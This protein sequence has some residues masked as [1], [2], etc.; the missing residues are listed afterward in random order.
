[1]G[2]D[3]TNSGKTPYGSKYSHYVVARGLDKDG[4]VIVEDSEDKTVLQDIVL[5]I[6]LII[7]QF[8]LLLVKVDT[9]EQKIML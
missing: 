9:V 1:M 4:N 3:S 5:L 2:R 6:H 7:L 8:E